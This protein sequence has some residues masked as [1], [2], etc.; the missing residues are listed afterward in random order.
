[1][2]ERVGDFEREGI[3]YLPAEFP[4]R[5]SRLVVRSRAEP[6]IIREPKDPSKSNWVSVSFR[7]YRLHDISGD[8]VLSMTVDLQAGCRG[9]TKNPREVKLVHARRA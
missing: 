7:V 8:V 1:M 9:L 6:R 2:T 3:A 5:V 4:G